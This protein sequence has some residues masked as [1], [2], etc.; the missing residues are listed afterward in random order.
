MSNY[1]I[2]IMVS[3]RES[4]GGNNVERVLCWYWKCYLIEIYVVLVEGKRWWIYVFCVIFVYCVEILWIYLDGVVEIYFC[5]Y[6][7]LK[8]LFVYLCFFS[9]YLNRIGIWKIF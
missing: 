7:I 1:N 8:L 3:V 4:F 2:F 6:Y 5:L 9:K